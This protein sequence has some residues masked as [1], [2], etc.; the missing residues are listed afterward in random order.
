MTAVFSSDDFT[1]TIV[2]I[3]LIAYYYTVD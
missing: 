3:F 1:A 2:H